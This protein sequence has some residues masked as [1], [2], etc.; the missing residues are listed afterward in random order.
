MG[1]TCHTSPPTRTHTPIRDHEQEMALKSI[2]KASPKY[3]RYR[4][5]ASNRRELKLVTRVCFAHKLRGDTLQS[6][7]SQVPLH[8]PPCRE[9]KVLAEP[10][11]RNHVQS[12]EQPD[13]LQIRW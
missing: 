7:G 3:V 11:T 2:S 12:T 6:R 13:C 1:H 4:K 9:G 8:Q 10:T 5:H